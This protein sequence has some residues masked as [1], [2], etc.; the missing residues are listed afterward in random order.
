MG[1]GTAW[2]GRL[3]CKQEFFRWVQIPHPPPILWEAYDV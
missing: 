2:G 1:D 3:L